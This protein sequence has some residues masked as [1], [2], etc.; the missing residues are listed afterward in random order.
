QFASLDMLVSACISCAILFAVEAA[1]ADP[2]TRTARFAWLAA[3]VAA[4][5]GVLA[6]GLIGAV[7]P[8]LVFVVWALLTRRPRAILTA[9]RFDGLVLF[10][11]ITVPWFML[12]E[13]RIP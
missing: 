6:K 1:E 11:L 12:V 5:L 4:G 8:G 9:L 10:A 3:Y 7:L 2:G 13:Q